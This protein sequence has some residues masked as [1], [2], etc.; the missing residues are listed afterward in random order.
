MIA[1]RKL[2]ASG[3]D[4][5][6]LDAILAEANAEINAALATAEAAPWPDASAAYEDIADTGAGVWK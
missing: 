3:A 2:L 4:E 5:A 6:S 1:R